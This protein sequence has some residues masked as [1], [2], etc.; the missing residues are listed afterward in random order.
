MDLLEQSVGHRRLKNE[1]SAV[2]RE[3]VHRGRAVAVSN[4][5]VIDGYL[6]PPE[7]AKEIDD[8][9]RLR[10]TLPLLMAAVASGAAVP[11][12]TLRDLG[13]EI[14]FDW[15]ELN[16]FTARAPVTFTQGTDGEPWVAMPDASPQRVSE[17]DADFEL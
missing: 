17:D 3:T 14:P 12:Q 2:L 6:V 10:E 13:I 9:R 1:L 7:A 11:S 5:G 15:R 16:R 4:R 8:A